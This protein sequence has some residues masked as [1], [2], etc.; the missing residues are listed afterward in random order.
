[1]NNK[2]ESSNEKK[3][4]TW[5]H[6]SF[7]LVMVMLPATWGMFSVNF[8]WYYET[9]VLL[10]VILVGIANVIFT[11]WDAFNDPL[12]GY[13]S[14]RPNRMTK[15]YGRRFPFI[16]I[17]GIPT[18]VSLILLF[19]PPFVDAKINPIPIFIWILIWLLIHELSYTAVSLARALYPEKFRSDSERR[20]NAGIGIFTYNLGM[21]MGLIVPMIFVVKGDIQSYLIGAIVLM[22]PCFICFFLGIPGVR[23]E[24]EMIERSFKA[25]K[26]PFLKTMKTTLKKKN[27]LALIFV[28]IST[29][30]FG[31][32]ILGSIYYYVAFILMEPPGSQADI[33]FMLFWFIAGLLSVP[34]WM[35][36]SNKVGHKKIQFIA[37]ITTVI[38]SIPFIF[39]NT[40]IGALIAVF[41]LGFVGGAGTFV[42]YPIFSDMIDE[43]AILDGKRQ[44]GAYQGILA[45]FDRFG[46]LLQPIIFTVIHIITGFNPES[47]I[48]TPLAQQGIIAAMTWIPAIIVLVA[49]LVFWKVYD[50]T[51]DKTSE[52]KSKLKELNL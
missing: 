4:S 50:L 33:L 35:K 26:E 23:E 24:K 34:F 17:F 20:K 37:I 39:L 3:Y 44:E 45:F 21:F 30:A 42:R 36:L 25:A 15:R 12:V 2:K 49:G 16:V 14:D 13:I 38:S 19:V 41:I 43:T 40:L 51:P 31:A 10:P 32:C 46:I 6:I 5:T 22:V 8:F 48:Q 18:M 11:L 27:F 9:E 28:S 29:Q 47:E 1:M 7:N 52:I